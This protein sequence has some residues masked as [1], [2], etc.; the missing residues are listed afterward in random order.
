MNKL[1]KVSLLVTLLSVGQT[2]STSIVLNNVLVKYAAFVA[3]IIAGLYSA[4]DLPG[5]DIDTG[6]WRK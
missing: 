2:N 4:K 5:L 6:A 3:L 1:L